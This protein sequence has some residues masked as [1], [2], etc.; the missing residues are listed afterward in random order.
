MEKFNKQVKDRLINIDHE[1][2]V[3]LHPTVPGIFDIQY[4]CP[5]ENGKGGYLDPMEYHKNNTRPKKTVY[6]PK[7]ISDEKMYQWGT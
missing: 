6:D 5:K 1:E 4:Q 7:I 3:R 2:G